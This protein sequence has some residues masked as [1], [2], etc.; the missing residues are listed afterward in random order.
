MSVVNSATGPAF[1]SNLV[2]MLPSLGLVVT[3]VPIS[4]PSSALNIEK[5]E[6]LLLYCM[7]GRC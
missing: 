5:Y 7:P 2:P 1:V 3:T 4:N 6:W